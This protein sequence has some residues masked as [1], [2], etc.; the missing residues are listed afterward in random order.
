MEDF[1]RKVCLFVALSL[2]L[3]VPS[4]AEDPGKGEPSVP[5]PGAPEATGGPDGFGYQFI[6]NNETTGLPPTYSL[7]DISTTGAALGIGDDEETNVTLPFAFPF[8]GVGTNMIRVGNNGGLL[9]GVTTGDLWAGNTCP[10]PVTSPDAPLI[11]AFWD[12]MDDETGNVY[13]Q[14]FNPCPHPDCDSQCAVFEWYDRPHYS[15]TGSA[16]FE[17]IL[18]DNGDILFQY[19]DVVFGDPANMDNGVSATVGIEDEGQNAA[20]FLPYSC[21]QAVITDG[22]AIKYTLGPIIPV[23]LQSFNI[24]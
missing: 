13:W 8:Y 17:A 24:D 3:A 23:E 22:L 21:N 11:M 10:Q 4:F 9:V 16:T 6:D 15:N 7:V 5:N 1:M 12:D 14:A 18:C 19:A 2:V 20:Y